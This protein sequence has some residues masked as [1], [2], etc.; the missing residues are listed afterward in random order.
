MKRKNSSNYESSLDWNDEK[1]EDF[2]DK[3]GYK[4]K[5]RKKSNS[6]SD[7]TDENKENDLE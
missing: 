1:H 5:K 2:S 3:K 4:C 7:W 6:D